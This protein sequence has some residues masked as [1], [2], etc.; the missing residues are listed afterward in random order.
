[1]ATYLVLDAVIGN[2]NRHHENWGILT[3]QRGEH[4]Y[5]VMAPSFDHA[6][7]L[8]RELQTE[9][10]QRLL[11]EGRVGQYSERARGGIFWAE[12]DRHAV[13]PLELVRRGFKEF[14]DLF[15][16]PIRNLKMFDAYRLKACVSRV[17]GDWMDATA[18]S[19][20]LELMRYNLSE[21][22]KLIDE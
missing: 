3:E 22:G 5:G 13:S 16:N 7:S 14:P 1:M 6:T 2:T 12:E 18:K 8:G 15:A 20:A 11:E 9:R 10:R 21:L 4:M 17:P 19:F